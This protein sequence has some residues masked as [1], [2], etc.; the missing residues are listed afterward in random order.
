MKII[1][2]PFLELH[3]YR[4]DKNDTTMMREIIAYLLDKDA[5][6]SGKV[7]V[8]PNF[9]FSVKFASVTD[10]QQEDIAFHYIN[11]YN[12]LASKHQIISFY[13]QNASGLRLNKSEIVTFT[14]IPD[15]IKETSNHAI[16]I[17]TEGE[18]VD[19]NCI[20][21]NKK[22]SKLIHNRF[23]DLCVNLDITY[24]AIC[25]EL[26]METP[27]ELKL[28]KYRSIAFKDFFVNTKYY[29]K[30]I[31]QSILDLSQEYNAYIE[32]LNNGYFISVNNSF[33]EKETESMPQDISD[34]FSMRVCKFI[35]DAEHPQQQKSPEQLI[36]EER[37]KRGKMLGG[38]ILLDPD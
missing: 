3:F 5:K 18:D 19:G 9:D 1:D 2:P 14:S 36:I 16:A 37:I 30:E 38:H 17:F 13:I 32:T 10:Y 11:E 25:C 34:R 7:S 28:L 35:A 23:I 8:F 15:A 22:L 20:L 12:E 6:L 29:S 4:L 26:G 21:N 27:E 33:R 24:A 31:I